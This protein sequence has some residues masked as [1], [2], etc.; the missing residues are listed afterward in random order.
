MAKATPTPLVRVTAE[1]AEAQE[2]EEALLYRV[3]N[4]AK[5]KGRSKDRYWTM[6]YIKELM[7]GLNLTQTVIRKAAATLAALV[8]LLA[9]LY[10]TV[11]V[12]KEGGLTPA[13]Q[14]LEETLQEVTEEM[15]EPT[16]E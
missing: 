10:G 6:K 9:G 11:T 8:V 5:P 13:L 1:E 3:N 12:Y 14:H 15:P 4:R 16:V 7:S 2:V